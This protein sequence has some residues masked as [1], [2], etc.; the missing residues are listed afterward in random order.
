M[1]LHQ[2]LLAI[3]KRWIT[4][5]ALILAGAAAGFVVAAQMTPVYRSTASVFIS[6]RQGDNTS[7]LLQGSTFAQNVV[8]SYAA[9]RLEVAR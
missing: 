5:V 1:D 6:A 2:Y 4:I 8:Q 7:E 9:N 3:R